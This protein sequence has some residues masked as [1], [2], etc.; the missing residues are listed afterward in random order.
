M[1]LE[2]I[3]HLCTSK[4]LNFEQA[5][6][7]TKASNIFTIHTPVKAGNDE[8]SPEL[9]NKYF[10]FYFPKLGLNRD[11]FLAL[12]R[13][14]PQK[15]SET[16]KM[17]VLALKLSTWR[18]GVSKLHGGV[19]RSMWAELWPKLP[20]D[21]VPIKSIT[22]GI[23]AKSFISPELDQLYE[24]YL[25]F[26]WDEEIADPQLW[27][28]VDQIPD[29]ELWRIHQRNRENLINFV[30]KQIKKQM[31][32]RGTY[33]TEL[34]WAE[35]VLDPEALTIGFARRFAT[36]KRGNLLLN[37][38]DRFI[39]LLNKTD[40]PVQFVFAGKAHPNDE[41]GKEIIRQL[42]HFA[43]RNDVRK[44]LVFLEDYNIDIARYMVQGVDIWLNNPRVPMEASGTSGMKAALNGALNVSTLD[45]WWCEGYSLNGGWVI[46]AGETYDDHEYQDKV[47]SEAIFDLF[48]NEIVPLFYTHSADNLPR[49]WIYRMKN[50]IKWI[51]PRFNTHRMVAEYSNRFYKPAAER[52]GSLVSAGMEKVKNAAT[53]KNR[54]KEEWK[55][56]KI[57]DVDVQIKNNG[58]IIPLNG[59]ASR[60]QVGCE[61]EI[62]AKVE[63]GGLNPDD[64]AVQIYHGTV[65]SWGNI[66]RGSIKEMTGSAEKTPQN[67]CTYTGTLKCTRS[68]KC[69]FAVRVLPGVKDLAD[70]YE[71]GMI[72]WEST[73]GN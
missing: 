16:F 64:V 41:Q 2:R 11:Q 66:S 44:R 59:N 43:N 22:N 53:L 4:G 23:H 60:L 32:R 30:R 65:D 25:G 24:R 73:N 3:R 57:D 47:E 70:Q 10:G 27:N 69:G 20:V 19:S 50:S 28:N 5:L 7:A 9:M 56:I 72:V 13:I 37:D 48:E 71:P 67:T 68:G 39:K 35:E 14:D 17:P 8:F 61:L 31:Q 6:E 40:K 54:L 29:E 51:V 63:L 58:E 52:W 55:N 49:A 33:H 34:G 36:Y 46:G 62:T 26:N 1:A 21:E 42:I 18:N 45:G 38:P 15:D 12:G